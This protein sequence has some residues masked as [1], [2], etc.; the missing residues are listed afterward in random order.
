M[1]ARK[2]LNLSNLL[3]GVMTMT[4]G[5]TDEIISFYRRYYG[6]EI[7]QLAQRY[8]QD[9]QSLTVDFS[10]VTQWSVEVADDWIQNPEQ[11]RSYMEE[12]LAQYDLPADVSL[13]GAKVRL[14]NLPEPR[15]FKPDEIPPADYVTEMITVTGQVQKRTGVRA[16]MTEAAWEC[17]RC[18]TKT[19]IPQ[20]D[21]FQEPHECQGCDRKGPFKVLHKES[22]FINRQRVRVTQPPED[23]KGGQGEHIDIRVSGDLCNV[24]DAGDR[25]SITGKFHLTDP[26]E[27]TG[28]FD[29]YLKAD[30]IHIEET[31]YDEIEINDELEQKIHA[32]ASGEHGDPYDLLVQSINPG[33]YGDEHIKLALALQMFGGVR[34]KTGTTQER[35]DWH[36]LLLGDPGCGKSTH[37]RAVEEV[38]PR[39][40]FASG[41]GATAAGLTASAVPDDFGSEKWS[42]QAGALVLANKGVACIDE[43][44]KVHED[45]VSSL[46]DALEAQRVNVNKAGIN[47]TLPAET[48]MLAAGNPEQGR[49]DP[50]EPIGEQIN[51]GPTLLSRFDLMF[52]LSD[53]PDEERD[54]EVADTMIANRQQAIRS[55]RDYGEESVQPD[56]E[57][58]TLRAWVAY[59]KKNVKPT[60][61]SEDVRDR[62]KELYVELRTAN[63]DDG[64]IP[65]TARKLEAFMRLAESSARV[66][67]DDEVRIS[68]AERASKLVMK[69]MRDVG[70]DPDTGEFDA[71]IVEA[72][73]SQSQ[74][75]RRKWILSVVDELGDKNEGPNRRDIVQEAGNQG[76]DKD[77]IDSD[78]DRLKEK[79]DIYE[80][81]DGLRTT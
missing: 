72:G 6:D 17:Q 66:R 73:S 44:D 3:P 58:D 34:A 35:G 13:D 5:L 56:V 64:P 26:D 39:S 41:K 28:E 47:A 43:I 71:D 1:V 67:L 19:Y 79:G 2:R 46:H 8:P 9:Q 68:D 16:A 59:A 12:A 10:D 51:L 18:S 49:F 48:A 38:A 37:L 77:L 25:V 52:M 81:G 70:V 40:T 63:G 11:I 55:E 20:T 15:E 33:H 45:A 57:A 69:S 23:V 31:D 53:S 78:I 22:E 27:D 30:D 29:Q 4:D 76:L 75:D 42:L 24:T 50:M 7:A 14:T 61:D 65:V 36:M 74:R 62:I 32:L 21:G 80:H 54:S 60:I